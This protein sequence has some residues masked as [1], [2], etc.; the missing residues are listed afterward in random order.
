MQADNSIFQPGIY[1]C[2]RSK[3]S[4]EQSIPIIPVGTLFHVQTCADADIRRQD[5]VENKWIC[6]HPRLGYM[7]LATIQ[8]MI[9]TCQGLDDIQGIAMPRNYI[10][11]N[12]RMGKATK[13]DQPS[14]IQVCSEPYANC[15]FGPFWALQ[16]ILFRRTFL[17][18][19]VCGRSLALHMGLYCQEQIRSSWCLQKVLCRYSH[20]S[21]Q[22]PLA[23]GSGELA[24]LDHFFTLRGACQRTAACCTMC[25]LGWWTS[26][27]CCPWVPDSS[28]LDEQQLQVGEHKRAVV[29]L[30]T[31]LGELVGSD[32]FFTLGSHPAVCC[33]LLSSWCR[34]NGKPG[35]GSILH[36]MCC[37]Q[38]VEFAVVC[39]E[40]S[41]RALALTASSTG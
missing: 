1:N 8:Q 4:V 15:S 37:Q 5:R 32:F 16:T 3:S 25:L 26:G 10:S 40:A 23:A 34:C 29:C 31:M 11:A 38:T 35:M 22:I 9:N 2:R 19:R 20:N 30:A 33:L 24:G 36:S 12:V 41:V 27:A 18:L 39:L 13:L 7:P 28:S 14:A 21:Q 6:W 17:L